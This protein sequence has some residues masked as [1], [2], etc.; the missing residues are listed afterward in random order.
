MLASALLMK[1]MAWGAATA[2]L[3]E[4]SPQSPWV[5][6]D[7]FSPCAK[8]CA[9]TL[10]GGKSVAQTDMTSMFLKFESPSTWQWDNTY[11]VALAIS[12]PLVQYGKYFSIDPEIGVARRFGDADGVEGWAALFV[13]WKYFPWSD[14]IRT[15]LGIGVGPSVSGD[16]EINR[17]TR[18]LQNTGSVGIANYFSPELTLGLPSEPTFDIVVRF[19]HRSQLWGLIPATTDATQ[20]W[21]I[22]L[23]ARF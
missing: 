6:T 13:R 23:K 16:V 17:E 8:D 10:F 11:V 7:L 19:H 4:E 1:A 3:A 21:T 20:F 2:A 12:R 14:Y 9:V 15:S 22:G 5:V 18:S